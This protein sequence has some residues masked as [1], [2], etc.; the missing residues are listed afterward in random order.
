[1][2]CPILLI[3]VTVILTNKKDFIIVGERAFEGRG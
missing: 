3:K 1:M 2:A